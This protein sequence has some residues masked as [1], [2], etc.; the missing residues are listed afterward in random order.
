MDHSVQLWDPYVPSRPMAV[1]SGHASA[2][3]DVI[4]NRDLGL[5][6]SCSQDCVSWRGGGRWRRGRYKTVPG[7]FPQVVRVWDIFEHF[8]VQSVSVKFPFSQQTPD[9]GPS[10]LH[11]L[12]SHSLTLLCNAFIAELRVGL[13]PRRSAT[14]ISHK[15]PLTAALYSSHLHQ[16]HTHTHLHQIHT[17][18][19][20]HILN[21]RISFVNVLGSEWL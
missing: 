6:F 7:S 19:H 1:L 8:M 16:V 4:I 21:N 15:H 17:H 10:P 9:F 11:L 14:L 18:S 12:P 5:V 2:V 20:V 3:L 13:G